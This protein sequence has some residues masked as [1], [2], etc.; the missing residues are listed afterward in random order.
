MSN[1]SGVC[2]DTYCLNRLWCAVHRR[3]S[4]AT[5]LMTWVGLWEVTIHLSYLSQGTLGRSVR[6]VRVFAMY[7]EVATQHDNA[8]VPGY[9]ILIPVLESWKSDAL[10]KAR[11]HPSPASPAV[12]ILSAHLVQSDTLISSSSPVKIAKWWTDFP[13]LMVRALFGVAI[14]TASIRTMI[15]CLS[16][17]GSSGF[18]EASAGVISLDRNTTLGKANVQLDSAYSWLNKSGVLAPVSASIDCWSSS[19]LRTPLNLNISF[20]P[21]SFSFPPNFFNFG[22]RVL[23]SRLYQGFAIHSKSERAP[24]GSMGIISV[25][26]CRI[27]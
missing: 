2:E 6:R 22:P 20:P 18:T 19:G 11:N 24:S 8:P 13:T 14:V 16:G 1:L 17:G 21:T 5:T 12:L 15:S 3:S 23:T 7:I 9:T 10:V 25:A 27:W 4:S 26:A